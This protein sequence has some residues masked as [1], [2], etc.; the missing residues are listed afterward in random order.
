MQNINLKNVFQS[1]EDLN[2]PCSFCNNGT[3]EIV[4]GTFSKLQT[5]ESLIE[6]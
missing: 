4:T 3:L 6:S 1:K 5:K 2:L